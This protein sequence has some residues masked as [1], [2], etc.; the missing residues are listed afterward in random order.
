MFVDAH[1]FM[2][3]VNYVMDA[4]VYLC[5]SIYVLMY[6]HECVCIRVY[7]SVYGCVLHCYR[8]ARAIRTR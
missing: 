3:T 7:M 2:C 5:V 1:V 6:V 4:S 8:L